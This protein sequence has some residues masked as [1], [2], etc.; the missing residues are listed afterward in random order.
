MAYRIGPPEY[1]KKIDR[2]RLNLF[3]FES[4]FLLADFKN[5]KKKVFVVCIEKDK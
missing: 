3:M 1:N 2:V 4:E 5:C